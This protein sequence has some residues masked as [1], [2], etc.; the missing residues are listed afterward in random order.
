MTAR[1]TET[2]LP[3]RALDRELGVFRASARE[4]S[5]NSGAENEPVGYAKAPLSVLLDRSVSAN[6][7]MLLLV[8]VAYSHRRGKI[9]LTTKEFLELAGGDAKTSRSYVSELKKA[10]YLTVSRV[11]YLDFEYAPTEKALVK[12]AKSTQTPA[13][14]K[15]AEICDSCK[16]SLPI[17]SEGVCV[18]CC[19]ERRENDA[20]AIAKAE[21]PPGATH[22]EISARVLVNKASRKLERA[23]RQVEREEEADAA[24]MG[25]EE[26]TA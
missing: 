4:I 9:R 19:R 25:P 8:I 2:T 18:A 3:L 1:K 11:N 7:R 10:G 17:T 15:L 22:Q 5:G 14:P 6:A 21:L 23:R 16:K 24:W 13:S 20:Y 12:F 26:L